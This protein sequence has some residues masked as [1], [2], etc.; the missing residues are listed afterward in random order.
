MGRFGLTSLGNGANY[1]LPLSDWC[2]CCWSSC[3]NHTSS[4]IHRPNQAGS[5]GM[6]EATSFTGQASWL[7]ENQGKSSI[8]PTRRV[9][10][11]K[12][13]ACPVMGLRLRVI[14]THS[15]YPSS[16]LACAKQIPKTTKKKV[17]KV[18]F[19]PLVSS[20][21][22]SQLFSWGCAS[23]SFPLSLF[24]DVPKRLM[25]VFLSFCVPQL[26]RYTKE[27][28]LHLGALG[29][30]TLL[31]DTRCLVDNVKS[32][33]PQLLDCE[34]VKSSLHKRWNFIQVC[35]GSAI[36]AAPLLPRLWAVGV[37]HV[38]VWD[39]AEI[40]PC[41]G[42]CQV[43]VQK[44]KVKRDQGQGQHFR[45]ISVGVSLSGSLRCM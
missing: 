8:A 22:S 32:R 1:V 27:G 14:L 2:C 7:P 6:P 5:P 4:F 11:P 21:P 38:A 33:F 3:A 13:G 16:S 15:L 18:D 39:K 30:T 36:D 10:R 12:G 42:G 37:W 34:K 28:F 31:P 17:E 44:E 19:S 35:Y 26:A 40:V 20:A 9:F 29:T 41:R 25:V 43:L 23:L 45:T 24:N